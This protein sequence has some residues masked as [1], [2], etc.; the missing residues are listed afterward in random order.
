[1]NVVLGCKVN[2]VKPTAKLLL[3]YHI[4]KCFHMLCNTKV[5]KV[6]AISRIFSNL[7][8]CNPLKKYVFSTIKKAPLGTLKENFEETADVI[9]PIGPYM[10]A[11][12][13]VVS[14]LD[15]VRFQ[16]LAVL[17][18]IVIEEVLITDRDPIDG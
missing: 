10:S 17:L 9:F 15:M 6:S 3:F 18:Y 14:V 1:M 12:T 4:R 2:F 16:P 8:F 7:A 13:L 11:C 5:R